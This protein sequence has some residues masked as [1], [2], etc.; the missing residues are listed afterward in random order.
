VSFKTPPHLKRVF[1]L[2]AQAKHSVYVKD[3]FGVLKMLK[4]TFV[5][6]FCIV[7]LSPY[8]YEF[9]SGTPIPALFE[10]LTT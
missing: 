8:A 1:A 5:G 4:S 3:R 10:S 9:S 2:F 7:C 6:E